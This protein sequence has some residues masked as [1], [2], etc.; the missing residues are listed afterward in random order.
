M[1][2]RAYIANGIR[3]GEGT[4]YKDPA[5]VEDYQILWP[6][7]DRGCFQ[8][9]I[10]SIQTSAW[11]VPAGLTEVKSSFNSQSATVWISGGTNGVNYELTNTITTNMG[12]TLKQSITIRVKVQ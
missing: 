5:S 3:R 9:S 11:N 12:R 6:Q 2:A 4:F 10:D 8:G 7:I 1:T